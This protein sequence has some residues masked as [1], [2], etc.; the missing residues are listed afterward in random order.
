ML[1][2]YIDRACAPISE[3]LNSAKNSQMPSMIV[4]AFI[5]PKDSGKTTTLAELFNVLLEE[6]KNVAFIDL[7]ALPSTIEFDP[8]S[9][10]IVFL[11]NAQLLRN[12]PKVIK[13]LQ[14]VMAT[15]FMAFSPVITKASGD[16]I[17]TCKI[18]VGKSWYFGPFTSMELD[19]FKLET[20]P[21]S[22]K[23]FEEVKKDAFP[24]LIN[25]CIHQ[26]AK[27]YYSIALFFAATSFVR[28]FRF[29]NSDPYIPQLILICSLR[30]LNSLTKFELFNLVH[31]GFAYYREDSN[32]FFLTY[33]ISMIMSEISQGESQVYKIMLAYNSGMALEFRFAGKVLSMIGVYT[34][35][36]GNE[37][38]AIRGQ[39]TK[40]KAYHLK[41]SNI[42]YQQDISSSIQPDNGTCTL[43][44][45]VEDHPALDFLI[46]DKSYGKDSNR[47]FFIQVSLSRYECRNTDKRFDSIFNTFKNF[48]DYTTSPFEHYSDK[49][50][51]Q[52]NNCFYVYVSPENPSKL[53]KTDD[54]NRIYFVDIS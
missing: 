5:G 7:V 36:L 32:S 44:K 18:K 13:W 1:E 27:N 40:K 26:K 54:Y 3:L 15:V 48:F 9:V 8:I 52:A 35:C 19:R 30:G 39:I 37:P 22:L 28:Q 2:K 14:G 11:D 41:C 42:I 47:L 31:T 49:L 21:E 34:E 29:Y 50:S 53:G 51:I 46:I 45:L 20:S 33:P 24:G 6:G 12:S 17:E 38:Q 4:H 43:V 23:F 16:T 25:K 10:E